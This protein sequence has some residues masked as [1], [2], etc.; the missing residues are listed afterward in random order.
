MNRINTAVALVAAALLSAC[1][2]S[3]NTTQVAE[4]EQ[5][6]I[7]ISFETD[8]ALATFQHEVNTRYD[9]GDA[10][11]ARTSW[12]IPFVYGSTDRTILSENAYFNAQVATADI[13][14]DGQITEAEANAYA[15][16][17]R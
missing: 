11:L 14:A 6:R 10:E 8:V 3:S 17:D 2:V 16:A 7:A 5:Q 1:L 12:G 13:D 15:L 4:P 9:D